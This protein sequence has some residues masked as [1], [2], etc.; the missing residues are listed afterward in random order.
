GGAR[1]RLAGPGFA[2]HAED[3]AG[4]DV[5]GDAVDRRE[6]AA[7][8]RKLD[9]EVADG[10]DR[11]RHQRSL[12]LSASRSQSPS[13]LTAS[14][15]RTSVT[16]GKNRIHHSPENRNCWPMRISVPS[17]GWVGGTPTP[18]KDS[19]ASSMM[20]SAR[21][22][23]PMTSTGPR[24]LGRMWRTRMRSGCTPMMRAAET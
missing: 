22:M 9:H 15:S 2:N 6:Q 1:H 12:G 13:R 4:H 18:R 20:A 10:D 21:P 23:V 5:E 24:T 8:Q 3:L 16:E 19:V 17:E 7:P 11:V 14:A